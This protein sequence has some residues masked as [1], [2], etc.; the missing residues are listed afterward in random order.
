MARWHTSILAAALLSYAA[1]SF[2]TSGPFRFNSTPNAAFSEAELGSMQDAFEALQR[3]ALTL[4][5]KI[6]EEQRY[7]L[8]QS[9]RLSALKAQENQVQSH[10]AFRQNM[11][12]NSLHHMI[13]MGRMSTIAWRDPRQNHTLQ[14]Q[15]KLMDVLADTIR[16]EVT[17]LRSTLSEL[18]LMQAS[19]TSTEEALYEENELLKERY[20]TL[21]T[22][23]SERQKAYETMNNPSSNTD[24]QWQTLLSKAETIEAL[25]MRLQTEENQTSPS[26]DSASV[27]AFHMPVLGPILYRYGDV[28]ADHEKYKGMVIETRPNSLILAPAEGRV[29]FAGQFRDYGEVVI[30]AHNTQYV[31]FISGISTL[32]VEAGQSVKQGEPVGHMENS[33]DKVYFE[34]RKGSK[35]IDPIPLIA[36]LS[37][38]S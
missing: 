31:S 23:L 27:S 14:R 9:E 6:K 26:P 12:S 38:N 30:F 28:K 13:R 8:S 1:P 22:V 33:P 16:H 5:K 29:L 11:L 7:T 35:A 2:A 17:S 21:I 37:N 10:L 32:L 3:D 24:T 4:S 20:R 25:M 34:L 18:S 19:I 36:H 15:G